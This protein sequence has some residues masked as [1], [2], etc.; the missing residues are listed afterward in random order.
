MPSC[1]AALRTS[2]PWRASTFWMKSPLGLLERHFFRRRS[3]G[4]RAMQTEVDRA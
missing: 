4:G 3:G 2:P 1:S